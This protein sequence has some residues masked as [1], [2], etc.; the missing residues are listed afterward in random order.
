M[1]ARTATP[2]STWVDA[3]ASPNATQPTPTPT[4][5]SRF[6]KAPASPAGTCACP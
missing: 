3:T 6:R 2:P 4:S 1:P 5:G